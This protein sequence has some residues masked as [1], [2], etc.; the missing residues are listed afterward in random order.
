MDT[1]TK[2][3]TIDEQEQKKIFSLAVKAFNDSYEEAI[4]TAAVTVIAMVY[5]FNIVHPAIAFAPGFYFAGMIVQLLIRFVRRFDTHYTVDE[6]A[7][8]VI[9][10]EASIKADLDEI[11]RNV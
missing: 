9:E 8:R 2:P 7:D 4:I 1:T 6:L 3:R 11:K 5:M 10:L